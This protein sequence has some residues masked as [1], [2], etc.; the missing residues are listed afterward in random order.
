MDGALVADG[1]T[2]TYPKAPAPSIDDVSFAIEPEEVV[3]LLGPNGAGKS[4]L[5][6]MICGVSQPTA[7]TVAVFGFDPVAEPMRAKARIAAMHQGAPLDMMLPS[8]E[9]LRIAARFRGLSWREVGPWV[10]ELTEFLGL[11]DS[12]R[13]LAFQ[14]SGG[15][16]QRLQ[17]ARAL[18][19]V[20]QLLILD[21]PSA[22]LDV[23]GRRM[24]WELVEWLRSEYRVT[25]LWASHNI[26]ELERNCD[27]VLVINKGRLLR[28]A[29]PRDL[30]DEFGAAHVVVT[31]LDERAAE[32]VTTWA[33]AEGCK[34]E[35]TGLDVHVHPGADE[36]AYSL[37]P[38]LAEQCRAT[39]IALQRISVE[40]DSLED[41]FMSLTRT[42]ERTNVQS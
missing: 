39:G 33:V 2:K 8:I 30:V 13:Q 5:I 23:A 10:A 26:D 29:R 18:L 20:P 17:L 19:A 6:R 4:T 3:G 1:L 28:F 22:A 32:A 27:R 11:K 25:V 21:E 37:L 41:V 36:D 34:A 15:Q 24:I 35:R 16:K 40:T 42:E 9:C 38:R 12:M 31:I 7:G 14:L